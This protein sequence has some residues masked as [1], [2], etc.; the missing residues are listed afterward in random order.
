MY[1][2]Y[3]YPLLKALAIDDGCLDFTF[4]QNKNV[5]AHKIINGFFFNADW[6]VS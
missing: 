1:T 4:K 6:A 3:F 5:S 2:N